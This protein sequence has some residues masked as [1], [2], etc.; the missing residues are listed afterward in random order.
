MYEAFSVA[1]RA[2]VT[3]R[4]VPGAGTGEWLVLALDVVIRPPATEEEK[5]GGTPLSLDD[6]HHLL[7]APL[8]ALLEIAPAV[9]EPLNDGVVEILSAGCLLIPNGGGLED[10]LRLSTYA[11]SRVRGA[12]DPAPST[13]WPGISTRSRSLRPG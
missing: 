3:L 9:V 10:Y 8:T 7:Y 11:R 6:F 5:G 1:A 12:S 13:G 4:P 2:H